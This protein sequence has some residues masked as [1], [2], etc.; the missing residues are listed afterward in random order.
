MRECGS[1]EGV[2]E[3][4]VAEHV[5]ALLQLVAQA[6]DPVLSEIDC[7]RVGR[8]VSLARVA[9]DLGDVDQNTRVIATGLIE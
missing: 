8:L 5:R 1:V 2:R 7:E 9:V 3:R 6:Q 4:D